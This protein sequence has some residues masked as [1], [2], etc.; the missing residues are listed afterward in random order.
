MPP[1]HVKSLGGFSCELMKTYMWIYGFVSIVLTSKLFDWNKTGPNPNLYNPWFQIDHFWQSI[2]RGH[3]KGKS[4]KSLL[5]ASV[6]CFTF[7]Q[8]TWLSGVDAVQRPSQH[9]LGIEEAL[10][11]QIDGWISRCLAV[12][13]D[14]RRANGKGFV[15]LWAV[16]MYREP[17]W[18]FHVS[19]LGNIRQCIR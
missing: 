14:H 7:L 4:L 11:S 10:A 9:D 18:L 8:Q 5:C 6:Y 2:T 13:K 19:I 15:I 12:W 16:D 17:L 3:S 1:T